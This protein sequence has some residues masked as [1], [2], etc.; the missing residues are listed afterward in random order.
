MLK[1]YLGTTNTAKVTAVRNVLEPLGLEIIPMAVNSLV[2]DQP[3]TDEE[4]IKGATNRALALPTDG[5]R[6]GLEAGVE[7]LDGDLFLTNYGV[8]IDQNNHVYKAGGT[9]IT[10]PNEVKHAIF[11]EGLELADA[12]EKYFGLHNVKHCDGA[13]GFFTEGMVK[14]VD[15]FEHIIKLLYGQYLHGGK[16]A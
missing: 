6:V 5:L 12:M 2:S 11:E 1:V 9:R 15:I 7:L 14:R 13:I 3:K 8:L 4:T 10:L 16:D